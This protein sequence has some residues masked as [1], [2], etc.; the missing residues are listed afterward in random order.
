VLQLLNSAGRAGFT[1]DDQRRMELFAGLLAPAIENARLYSHQKDQF[2]GIV[3]ALAEAID[4]RDPY[5]GD[6]VR[7]VVAYSLLLGFEMGLTR[8]DLEQLRLAA[9]LHDVGKIAVPDVILQKPA[10]L[11]E[12]EFEVMKQHVLDGAAIVS[13]FEGLQAL[14]AVVRHHHEHIDGSGY[15]DGL[16]G[17]DI[18]LLVRIVTVADAFDAMTTSRP[19]RQALAHE[20]AA[21]EL[22]REAGSQFCPLVVATF[23]RLFEAGSFAV[24]AG[25]EVFR[26]LDDGHLEGGR[27]EIFA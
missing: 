20:V 23:A 8:T 17:D 1:T 10:T 14:E 11:D 3:M 9:S 16:A 18:P 13:R 12:A 24:E 5:T 4:R 15:P 21:A 7:R 19:Y 22:A 6:H 27:A 26:L 25:Q 2:F